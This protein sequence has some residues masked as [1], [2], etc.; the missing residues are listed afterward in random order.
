MC[1]PRPRRRTG[2]QEETRHHGWRR[3]HDGANAGGRTE[4]AT[5]V[6]EGTLAPP[7]RWARMRAALP[8][9]LAGRPG[10]SPGTGRTRV[11][12]ED[13]RAVGDR[14]AAAGLAAGDV[15]ACRM[16]RVEPACALVLPR[17]GA[18]LRRRVACRR[19]GEPD[20]GLARASPG[21]SRSPR[22]TLN[23]CSV[24]NCQL[25]EL[26]LRQKVTREDLEVRVAG[27]RC[28]HV[29]RFQRLRR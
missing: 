19:R 11:L 23:A 22:E 18:T 2:M 26:R 15:T 24:A 21:S 13:L 27:S 28:T 20:E 29:E 17:T 7:P 6:G 5:G 10:L 12:V 14:G 16:T 25:R 3:R 1:G 9:I 8:A 4:G